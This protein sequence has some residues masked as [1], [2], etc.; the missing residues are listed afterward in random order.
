VIETTLKILDG[1]RA[2][3]IFGYINDTNYHFFFL[4]DEF[5][6]LGLF[7]PSLG[8]INSTGPYTYPIYPTPWIYNLRAIIYENTY[9]LSINGTEVLTGTDIYY[10]SGQV[11]L[12][13]HHGNASFD[14]FRIT[15]LL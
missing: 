11:G 4:S 14:D 10:S 2:G 3:I 13:V 6:Q 8:M 7:N 9:S 5:D 12:C 15:E 1:F